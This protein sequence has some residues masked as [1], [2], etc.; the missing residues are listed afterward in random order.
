[1]KNFGFSLS[2]DRQIDFDKSDKR[3]M[4]FVKIEEPT[5]N[6]CIA[7][8]TCTATCSA[9]NFTEMN[10]RKMITLIKRGE[11]T[12]V[13]AELSKCM[14]CGKCSLACPRGVNTRNVI[15]KINQALEKYSL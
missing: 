7:C 1:M 3:I 12:G 13:R 10:L 9:G 6:I 8:G 5:F 14:L 11:I 15:F 4:D 2:K